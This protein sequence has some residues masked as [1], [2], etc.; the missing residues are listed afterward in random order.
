MGWLVGKQSKAQL[1]D[2]LKR[3]NPTI[4][5]WSLVG[6][7]LWGLYPIEHDIDNLDLKAGTLTIQLFLIQYYGDGEYGYKVMSENAHPYYY[8][9]PLKFLKK[10][11]VLNEEWRHAVMAYHA[12]KKKKATK[13]NV[14]DIVKLKNTTIDKVEIVTISPLT[15]LDQSTG[16]VYKIPRKYIDFA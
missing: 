7:H 9:C 11:R 3:G 14:G 16:R 12:D 15:G 1:V 6:N 4:K 10:T 13:F 8:T 2:S 5:E